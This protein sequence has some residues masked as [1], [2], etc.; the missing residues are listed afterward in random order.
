MDLSIED[1]LAEAEAWLKENAPRSDSGADSSQF[2]WGEG[3]F[4]VAVFHALSFDEEKALIDDLSSWVKKKAEKG[5][6]AIS[7]DP[8]YGGLGLSKAHN[9]E[10]SELERRYVAPRRHEIFS[11]TQNLVASAKLQEKARLAD[12]EASREDIV[13]VSYT[14]L[15]LPTNREV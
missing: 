8:Q 13:P 14:H 4:S 11:V 7:A 9:R 6:H 15:T 1:F 3:T 5:Y 2:R 10:F 12:A